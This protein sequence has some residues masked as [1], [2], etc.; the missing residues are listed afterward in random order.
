MKAKINVTVL[1]ARKFNDV[2]D[3][4]K[5]DFTKLN[6]QMPVSTVSGNE[7]GYNVEVIPFGDHSNF[8]QMKSLPFP[9]EAELDIELTTKGMVCHG[10]RAIAKAQQTVKAAA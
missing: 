5:Y 1:G 9:V 8:E 3:G 10:F 2:V 6:V 4:V 7:V